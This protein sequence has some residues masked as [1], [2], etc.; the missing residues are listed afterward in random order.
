MSSKHGPKRNGK[1]PKVRSVKKGTVEGP[2]DSADVHA[3]LKTLPPDTWIA[4][5]RN[6][7][8]LL[9]VANDYW[10]VI[11]QAAEAGEAKPRIEL[12]PGLHNIIS[13]PGFQFYPEESPDILEEVKRVVPDHE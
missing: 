13:E 8:R 1:Q 9:A 3:Y 4:W 11:R 10:D 7:T 6:G 5:D 2:S 12:A